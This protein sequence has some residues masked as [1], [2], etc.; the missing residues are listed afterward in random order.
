[1]RTL[2]KKAARLARWHRRY[3]VRTAGAHDR[4]TRWGGLPG[5]LERLQAEIMLGVVRRYVVRIDAIRSIRSMRAAV[6]A[7]SPEWRHAVVREALSTSRFRSRS[8][9]SSF[10]DLHQV[11]YDDVPPPVETDPLARTSP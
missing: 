11:P 5:R 6:E 9:W 10:A 4:W 7:L 3:R 1:M 2:E 8:W